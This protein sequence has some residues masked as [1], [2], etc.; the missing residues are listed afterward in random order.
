MKT[1]SSP[2]R[3]VHRVVLL[4]A[5]LATA[6]LVVAS[7]AVADK[8]APGA[9]GRGTYEFNGN[10]VLFDFSVVQTNDGGA[11][12][13]LTVRVPNV[14][15]YEVSDITGLRV[16]GEFAY[17]CGVITDANEPSVVGWP[18]FLVVQDVSSTGEGD[19]FNPGIEGFGE[20]D[21]CH[22]ES[23]NLFYPITSGNISVCERFHDKPAP[24][25]DKCKTGR[26][27]GHPSQPARVDAA[28]TTL[29]P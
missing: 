27:G 26:A 16:E 6:T 22:P 20:P 7:P 25:A 29:A 3:L 12:G 8:P 21:I 15:F 23:Q 17:L 10:D 4:A 24:R 9:F 2:H 28:G 5:S 1:S 14:G 13:T 11:S 19:M 18:R